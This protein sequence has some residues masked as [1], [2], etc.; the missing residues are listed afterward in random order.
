MVS[1]M[2]S[3]SSVWQTYGKKETFIRK[4][5]RSETNAFFF[6]S[7]K[8]SCGHPLVLLRDPWNTYSPWEGALSSPEAALGLCKG[9]SNE[10]LNG[11]TGC[12]RVKKQ[13]WLQNSI[14]VI[15]VATDFPVTFS[16]DA[17]NQKLGIG[18]DICPLTL[19][20]Y[21]LHQYFVVL[22][23]LVKSKSPAIFDCDLLPKKVLC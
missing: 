11:T 17:C 3:S 14:G 5:G 7:W 22:Q 8:L 10:N 9:L 18:E 20:L 2:F 21:K 4:M 6:S 12:I 1:E 23:C 13:K 15:T 19:E 16:Y